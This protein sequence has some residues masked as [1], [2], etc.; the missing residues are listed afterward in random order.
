MFAIKSVWKVVKKDDRVLILMPNIKKYSTANLPTYLLKEFQKTLNSIFRENPSYVIALF[1]SIE[2]EKDFLT[3][4]DFYQYE[5][6][7]INSLSVF[8][9]ETFKK[10]MKPD[11]LYSLTVNN[12]EDFLY[13]LSNRCVDVVLFDDPFMDKEYIEIVKDNGLHC[14]HGR[15]YIEDF[16]NAKMYLKKVIN[17]IMKPLKGGM[18]QNIED[19]D[20]DIALVIGKNSKMNYNFFKD[21]LY[22]F[23]KRNQLSFLITTDDDIYKM[24]KNMLSDLK[25]HIRVYKMSYPFTKN[26]IF[27]LHNSLRRTALS[28]T[29]YVFI[30]EFAFDSKENQQLWD[31]KKDFLQGNAICDADAMYTLFP[32]EQDI[33]NSKYRLTQNP[34]GMLHLFLNLEDDFIIDIKTT[35]EPLT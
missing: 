29:S 16:L 7:Q 4:E 25:I 31:E 2:S 23:I 11:K 9:N 30:G 12:I 1:P 33:E 3:Y 8:H 10:Y 27:N 28:Y 26:N 19:D 14:S 6:Q 34:L 35:D 22:E 32:E 21:I 17:K 24:T 18:H 20:T 13:H 15:C 5:I